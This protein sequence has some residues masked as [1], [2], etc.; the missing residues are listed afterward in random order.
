MNEPLLDDIRVLDLSRILAGPWATQLLAD[1]GAGADTSVDRMRARPSV[2]DTLLDIVP[3]NPIASLATANMLQ[4][5]FFAVMFGV[6][7]TLM[8]QEGPKQSVLSFFEGVS[9]AMIQL[10]DGGVVDGLLLPGVATLMIW[11]GV[12]WA[13]GG[14]WK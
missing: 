9:D 12:S 13:S 8:P 7:L 11:A 5:I 3:Q 10:V 6:A 1:Y 4:I 14:G 2:T